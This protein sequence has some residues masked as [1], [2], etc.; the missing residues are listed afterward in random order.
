MQGTAK[1]FVVNL[2]RLPYE[3]LKLYLIKMFKR[4]VSRQEVYRQLQTIKLKAEES[5]LSYA[6]AM[7]SIAFKSNIEELKLVDIRRDF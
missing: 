4:T 3:E 1:T 5:C 7:Q 2:G 6:I